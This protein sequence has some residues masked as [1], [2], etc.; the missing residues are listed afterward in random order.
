MARM[1]E[2]YRNE[3][4]PAMMKEFGYTNVMQAP[5]LEKVVLNM[6]VGTAV[7]TNSSTSCS[8]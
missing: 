4:I 6:G 2:K 3:V 1:K 5:R 7:H 8:M